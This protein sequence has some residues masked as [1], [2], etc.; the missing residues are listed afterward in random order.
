MVVTPKTDQFSESQLPNYTKWH[1]LEGAKAQGHFNTWAGKTGTK[2]V[3]FA[4]KNRVFSF[5]K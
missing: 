2:P 3:T 5:I 1:V 4:K